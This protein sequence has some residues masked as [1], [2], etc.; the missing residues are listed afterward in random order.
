MSSGQ[1]GVK[2]YGARTY[3]AFCRPGEKEALNARPKRRGGREK[4]AT[5]KRR[6]VRYDDR[7]GREV[8]GTV[9]VQDQGERVQH[10]HE[11]DQGQDGGEIRGGPEQTGVHDEEGPGQDRGEVRGG[12]RQT[13][14]QIDGGEVTWCPW[15]EWGAS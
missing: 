3:R 1:M 12:P 8:A 9:R 15:T 13:G 2:L 10:H 6:R 14:A 4:V 5:Y 11:E 7:Q